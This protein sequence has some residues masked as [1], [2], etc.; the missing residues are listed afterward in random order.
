M[1]DNTMLYFILA[2]MCILIG[3]QYMQ[4]QGG[5]L[6]ALGLII[7]FALAIQFIRS[8]ITRSADDALEKDHNKKENQILEK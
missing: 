5:M 7:L 1:K 3:A 8:G 2:L 4:E 6:I